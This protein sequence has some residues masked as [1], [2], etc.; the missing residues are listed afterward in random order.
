MRKGGRMTIAPDARRSGDGPPSAHAERLLSDKAYRLIEEKIVT[1]ALAPGFVLTEGA[2]AADLGLGRT[3]LRE[4]LQRLAREGLVAFLPN[5]GVQ[6]SRIDTEAQLRLLEVR[7]RLEGLTAALAAQRA[8]A[9]QRECFRALDR[10]F[11]LVV[12]HEDEI[13]FLRLDRAFNQLLAEA[14]H[15]P[16]CETMMAIIEGQARRFFYRNRAALNLARTAELHADIAAA[17]VAGDPAEA[18]TAVNV[19]L[20]YNEGFARERLKLS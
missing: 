3:P 6:I 11:Q 2:L 14:A 5:K 13:V 19:L 7:R 4:A 9:E 15:N 18:E 20:D 17:V 10:S 16:Y 1:L 12:S 8:T